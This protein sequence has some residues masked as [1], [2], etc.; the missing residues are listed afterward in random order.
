[1]Y[2]MYNICRTHHPSLM[3]VALVLHAF[4]GVVAFFRPRLST[5]FWLVQM[6]AL[7]ALF[8][9]QWAL[10]HPLPGTACTRNGRPYTQL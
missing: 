5:H 3:D 4:V 6:Y 1:M 2:F 10:Y 9:S 8:C 7:W